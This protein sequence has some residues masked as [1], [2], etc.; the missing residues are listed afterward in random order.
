MSFFCSWEFGFF[1]ML[2]NKVIKILKGFNKKEM[3]RFKE[4]VYS[5][6]FNKHNGVR[7]LVT[8]LSSIYPKFNNRNCDRKVI[9]KTLFSAQRHDQAHLALLFT[10]TLR[11]L[12]QYLSEEEFKDQI[13]F[14]HILL[15][16]ALRQRKQFEQYEKILQRAKKQLKQQSSLDN[17]FYNWGYWLANET[18]LYYVQIGKRLKDDS[19]QAMQNNLN[20]YYFAETL[21]TAV[22]MTIRTKILQVEYETPMLKH[23][24][25]TI[26]GK[27]H[28]I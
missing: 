19:I 17:H 22:E 3:T 4:F 13:H 16:S 27:I 2:D 21:R 6:Y 20:T 10:Y 18:D 25:E 7:K 26:E 14:Q 11:L 15:L 28:I 12:E 24:L 9:F 8:Y 1:Y 5:P 23:V